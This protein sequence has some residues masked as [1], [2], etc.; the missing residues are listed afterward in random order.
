MTCHHKL[1][2]FIFDYAFLFGF[3]DHAG[4]SFFFLLSSSVEAVDFR[5]DFGRERSFPQF[6]HLLELV[7]VFLTGFPLAAVR[8]LPFVLTLFFAEC[9][10]VE[11]NLWVSMASLIKGTGHLP[12]L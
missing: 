2:K 12:E 4:D 10:L 7:R 6:Y 8:T 1:S 11:S 5:S 9:T 3:E